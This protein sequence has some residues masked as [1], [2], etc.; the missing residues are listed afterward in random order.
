MGKIIAVVVA[1]VVCCLSSVVLVENECEHEYQNSK[2]KQTASDRR[3]ERL[4]SDKGQGGLQATRLLAGSHGGLQ[5]TMLHNVVLR[6]SRFALLGSAQ[7]RYD[8]VFFE[9]LPPLAASPR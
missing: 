6:R 1:V 8:S 4:T 7:W 5:A 3:P 9:S 2:R